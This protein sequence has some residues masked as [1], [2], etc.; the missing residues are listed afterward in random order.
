MRKTKSTSWIRYKR[1][2]H[3]K[4][5]LKK[6]L[7]GGLFFCLL[8]C[9]GYFGIFWDGLWV[10]NIEI[11]G[12]GGLNYECKN[13]AL[14]ILND[15]FY[16]IIPQKSIL[17]VP[18]E[19]IK[20]EILKKFPKIGN[21][22]IYKKFPHTLKIELQ[23]REPVGI[24]C[25]LRVKKQDSN[26]TFKTTQDIKN[27]IPRS[28]SDNLKDNREISD[29]YNDLSQ[30]FYIDKKGVIF[31][32]APKMEGGLMA[33]I[34]ERRKNNP[35]L[36]EKVI[37]EENIDFI[38]EAEDRLKS[39][40]LIPIIFYLNYPD[41]K[42]FVKNGFYIYLTFSNSLDSQIYA[43]D[44]ALKGIKVVENLQYID[45]RIEGRVYYK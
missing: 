41:V 14:E 24:W 4:N 18:V 23:E 43:L 21:A 28:G 35:S 12:G 13:I 37:Y 15:R 26:N 5:R 40:D 27:E 17:I 45:L 10:R 3:K 9:V 42:V 29:L 2:S 30:C 6:Y 39:E 32:I 16:Y 44:R 34:Y 1:Q 36:G 33:N 11:S 19:K 25:R 7:F 38:L 20:T 31:K 22:R 8:I